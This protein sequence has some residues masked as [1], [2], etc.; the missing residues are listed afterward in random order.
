MMRTRERRNPGACTAGVSEDVKLWGIDA[1]EI[2]PGSPF[3]QAVRTIARRH[4]VSLPHAAVIA[5][6]MRRRA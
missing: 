4:R 2:I 5:E 6:L 3:M 1:S